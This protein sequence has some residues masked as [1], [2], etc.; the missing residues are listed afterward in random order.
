M[1]YNTTY[2]LNKTLFEPYFDNPKFQI[3]QTIQKTLLENTI[4]EMD[5]KGLN[6]AKN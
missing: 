4:K 5:N 6:N 2:S 1:S 3:Q